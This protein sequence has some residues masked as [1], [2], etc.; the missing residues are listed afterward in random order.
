MTDVYELRVV[1]VDDLTAEALEKEASQMPPH[2]REKAEVLRYQAKLFR[3]SKNTQIV[4]VW[5][6]KS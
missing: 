3:E 4:H 1:R 2:F 5:R 6:K